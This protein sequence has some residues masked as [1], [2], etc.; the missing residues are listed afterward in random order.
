[1]AAANTLAYYDTAGVT[2]VKSCKCMEV[3]SLCHKC[4]TRV[5]TTGVLI[6]AAHE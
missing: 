2:T 1:M 4:Q 3:P 5:T 6:I